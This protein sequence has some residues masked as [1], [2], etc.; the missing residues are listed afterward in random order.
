MHEMST[1]CFLRDCARTKGLSATSVAPGF[2]P[3][4]VRHIVLTHL[5][6]DHA[7]GLDDFAL[8]AVHML[9]RE[10]DSAQAQ[11]SWLDR[12]RYRPARW[13]SGA[14][15]QVHDRSRAASLRYRAGM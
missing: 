7:G 2:R 10:R 4:D 14:R 6:F 5:D 13:G 9:R 15:W 12:Q 8:A 1:G 3:E 11:R